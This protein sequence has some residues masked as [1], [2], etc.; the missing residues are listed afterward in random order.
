MVARFDSTFERIE[1]L[2][3]QSLSSR[4]LISIGVF[5]SQLSNPCVLKHFNVVNVGRAPDDD[6]NVT[7]NVTYTITEPDDK[8]VLNSY[9]KDRTLNLLST[10]GDIY[11]T[12]NMIM[13]VFDD[14]Y[15]STIGYDINTGEVFLVYIRAWGVEFRY[16]AT[17]TQEQLNAFDDLN[18]ERPYFIYIKQDAMFKV[19]DGAEGT[20]Y[21]K[22][23]LYIQFDCVHPVV[24]NV[25]ADTERI[26]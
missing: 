17:L 8:G 2:L 22:K 5:N 11:W 4:N 23:N 6:A 19:L 13:K 9:D 24:L 10:T 7:L 20:N 25:V 14:E 16:F 21:L 26:F 1:T 18:L 3:Q 15:P 12:P